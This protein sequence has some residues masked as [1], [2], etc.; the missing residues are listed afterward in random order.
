MEKGA[1]IHISEIDAIVENHVPLIELP[2]HVLRSECAIQSD[3]R[4]SLLLNGYSRW[5]SYALPGSSVMR[6]RNIM[7]W[8]SIQRRWSGV[9][10]FDSNKA[11]LPISGKIS[12]GECLYLLLLWDKDML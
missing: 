1:A 11:S 8:G 5:G 12:T 7:I 9:G 2:I 4:F 10:K 3:Y 6:S